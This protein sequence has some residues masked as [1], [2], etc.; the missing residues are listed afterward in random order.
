MPLIIAKLNLPMIAVSLCMLFLYALKGVA[1]MM[2]DEAI[3]SS[4]FRRRKNFAH[5]F[6]EIVV[7]TTTDTQLKQVLI[8]PSTSICTALQPVSNLII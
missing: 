4:C 2:Q 5:L 1:S 6:H 8:L 7:T 3:A